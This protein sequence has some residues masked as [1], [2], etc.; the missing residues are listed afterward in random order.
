M[1]IL[2]CRYRM[3]ANICLYDKRKKGRVIV[4]EIGQSGICS[5]QSYKNN[6]IYA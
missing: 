4:R 6:K 2:R 3:Q 5:A 1:C